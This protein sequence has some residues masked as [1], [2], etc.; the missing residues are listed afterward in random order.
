MGLFKQIKILTLGYA[1]VSRKDQVLDRQ[2]TAIKEYKPDIEDINI[3]TDKETGKTFNRENYL[4][5]KEFIKRYRHL[6]DKDDLVIE[7]IF[8]ELDRLGRDY[9]GIM[10]ELRWFESMDVIV[11]I[12]EMPLT[13]TEISDENRWVI[14]MTNHILIEVYAQLAEQEL[15]K[16]EKRQREG[17][18]EAKKKGVKFGRRPVAINEGLF[19]VYAGKAYRGESSHAEAMRKLNLKS[20]TYWNRFNERFPD[21]KG[22]EVKKNETVQS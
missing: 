5:M 7:V 21:Y 4:V 2:I 13:L 3:F 6:H 22:R 12:L 9:K 19:E 11:R 14:E 17:I 15:R 20:G 1:R 8:E 10:N 18:A 16:R